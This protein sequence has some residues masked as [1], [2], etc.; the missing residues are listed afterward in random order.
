MTQVSCGHTKCTYS[1]SQPT[2]CLRLNSSVWIL[3]IFT[4]E[5]W[6]RRFWLLPSIAL[7]EF[8]LCDISHEHATT[9]QIFVSVSLQKCASPI[10]F[11]YIGI[12]L[13]EVQS[14]STYMMFHC[15]IKVT[16]KTQIIG[17]L[18]LCL[19]KTYIW[20]QNLLLFGV[21]LCCLPVNFCRKCTYKSSRLMFGVKF[22]QT[23][24]T[25]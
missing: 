21:S 3:F 19:F 23:Y 13:H 2:G 4:D 12:V 18:E 9:R 24:V 10:F 16:V 11:S 14:A 7:S 25:V 22:L 15:M 5:N 17:S 6:P 20:Y 8:G 1:S